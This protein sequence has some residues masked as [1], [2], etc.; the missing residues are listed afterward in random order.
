MKEI[1]ELELPENVRYSDDHEWARQ[2]GDLI[3][4]GISDYAQDQLGDII[5]WSCLKLEKI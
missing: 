5:L 1:N 2:E 3:R 4:M